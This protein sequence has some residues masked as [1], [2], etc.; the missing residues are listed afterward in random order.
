MIYSCNLCDFKAK[1]QDGLKTHK[2]SIHKDPAPSCNQCGLKFTKQGHLNRHLKILH[3]HICSKCENKFVYKVHLK[4][5][6][7]LVHTQIVQSCD[8][9][10]FTTARKVILKKHKKSEHGNICDQCNFK[11]ST[12]VILESHRN[13]VHKGASTLLKNVMNKLY[14]RSNQYQHKATKE[15]NI[16]TEVKPA[17]KCKKYSCKQCK[18]KFTVKFKLNRH[19]KIVHDGISYPCEECTYIATRQQCLKNHKT[20]NHNQTI[21]FHQSNLR[22]TQRMIIPRQA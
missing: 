10:E 20:I 3:E 2:I 1:R 17:K 18:L 5:H 12:Q 22:L 16:E 8:Q 4:R 19:K 15:E 21:N 14:S 6:L 7:K 11:A 9:C 13:S